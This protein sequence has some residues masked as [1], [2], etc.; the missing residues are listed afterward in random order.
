MM[1]IDIVDTT[2][3]SALTIMLWI[4]F[5]YYESIQKQGRIN[6][7]CAGYY[8]KAARTNVI[9]EIRILEKELFFRSR[10][11]SLGGNC[12]QGVC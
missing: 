2:L 4:L 9:V 12:N 5:G 7:N 6:N 10:H 8:F 3:R 11:V 1:M